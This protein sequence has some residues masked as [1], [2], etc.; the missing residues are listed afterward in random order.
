[1]T[2]PVLI[3]PFAA[4]LAATM[5]K[6]ADATEFSP[7]SATVYDTLAIIEPSAFFSYFSESLTGSASFSNPVTFSLISSLCKT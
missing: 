6:A 5:R 3:G 4:A 2:T 7:Y 1:M